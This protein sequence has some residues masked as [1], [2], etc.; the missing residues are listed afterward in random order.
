MAYYSCT[1]QRYQFTPMRVEEINILPSGALLFKATN[2]DTSSDKNLGSK[3]GNPTVFSQTLDI[4]PAGMLVETYVVTE[5]LP[6]IIGLPEEKG[7]EGLCIEYLPD[8]NFCYDDDLTLEIPH[9]LAWGQ[10]PYFYICNFDKL[11]YFD[12]RVI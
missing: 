2:R 12:T 1:N 7:F 11:Q 9:P 6:F 5:D 4:Y 8:E 3:N 10:E